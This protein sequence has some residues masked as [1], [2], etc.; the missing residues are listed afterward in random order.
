MSIFTNIMETLGVHRTHVGTPDIRPLPPKPVPTNGG[1]AHAA[2]AAPA[3]APTPAAK[4]MSEVDVVAELEKRAEANPQQLYWRSSIVDLLKLLDVDSSLESRR[5]L[6][7]ELGAPSKVMGDSAHMNLWL[8]KEVLKRVAAN[9][10][11]VPAN[12]LD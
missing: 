8:H 10:G 9:G 4:P 12:L 6:A 11:N 2:P 3:P 5:E 1:S 7:T